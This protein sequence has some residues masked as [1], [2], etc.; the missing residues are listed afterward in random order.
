[1][2]LSP[3]LIGTVIAPATSVVQTPSGSEEIIL[4][5]MQVE[6]GT[7]VN[8]DVDLATNTEFEVII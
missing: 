5:V 3:G 2:T 6:L 7:T 1:M 8:F 4:V